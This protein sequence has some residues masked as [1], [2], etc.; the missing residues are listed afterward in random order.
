MES[1]TFAGVFSNGFGT[2]SPQHRDLISIRPDGASVYE[3]HPWEE[4]IS[5]TR[6]WVGDDVAILDY[7]KRLAAVGEDPADYRSIWY[8]F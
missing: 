7:L 2:D 8:Y 5:P 3:F 6:T 4:R 1:R